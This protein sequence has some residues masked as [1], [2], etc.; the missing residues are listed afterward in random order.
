MKAERGVGGRCSSCLEED[1]AIVDK[2]ARTNGEKGLVPVELDHLTGILILTGL[3]TGC[4][5]R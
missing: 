2:K 5:I 4:G 3:M 1:F